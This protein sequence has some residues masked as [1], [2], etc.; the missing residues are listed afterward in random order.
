MNSTWFK[1]QLANGDEVD[2]SWLLYSPVNKEAYCFCCLLFPTSQSSFE[3]AGEFTNWRHTER[4]KDH[5]NSPCHSKS[6][7]IW[8]EAERRI[9]YG[10]GIDLE[11]EAQIESEKQHWR[12]ILKRILSCIKVLA[13]QKVIEKNLVL[14]MKEPILETFLLF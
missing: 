12:N 6:Y 4:L 14:L 2:R 11:L 9:I 5:E 8:K 13:F 10:K 1:R 3:S 7:P